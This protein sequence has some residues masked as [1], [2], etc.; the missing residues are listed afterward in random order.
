MNFKNLLTADYWFAIDRTSL[1]L[2]DK[3]VFGIGIAFI[4][5]A[6]VLVLIRRR[7]Q[8]PFY[9][10][11]LGKFSNIF[12]ITGALEVVWFGFRYENAVY[13]GTLFVAAFI[14]LIFLLRAGFLTKL[15]IRNRKTAL[16][17]W[18]REQVKNKYLPKQ[19]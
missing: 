11:L 18:Q 13:L 19:R 12:W 17:A 6:I 8:S 1:H 10:S 5:I 7:T 9:R 3:T 16:Q 4:V 15:F 2:I 14:G